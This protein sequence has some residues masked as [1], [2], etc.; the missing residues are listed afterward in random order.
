M[1]TH[2][3]IKNQVA[4]EVL[5]QSFLRAITREYFRLLQVRQEYAKQEQFDGTS[6][7]LTLYS[8]ARAQQEC[9]LNSL[10]HATRH[11]GITHREIRRSFKRTANQFWEGG[12]G[13]VR[14]SGQYHFAVVG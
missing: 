9:V 4:R 2:E 7:M 12:W 11:S 6:Q 3:D 5:H 1:R 14:F 8:Y 13:N 10:L